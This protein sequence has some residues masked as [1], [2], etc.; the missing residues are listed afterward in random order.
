MDI[1]YPVTMCA[2]GRKHTVYVARGYDLKEGTL[3]ER[4]KYIRPTIFLGVPRVYEKVMEKMQ[5]VGA[6]FKGLVKKLSEAA[7]AKNKAADIAAQVG[8][9]GA[10]PCC[11]SFLNKKISAKA[12]DKLGLDQC[13][14]F[15]TGAA[16]MAPHV[17]EYWSSL[18]MRILECYGMSESTGLS[19]ANSN[20]CY[21][22]GTVG[23]PVE[24]V[25]VKVFKCDEQDFSKKKECPLAKDFSRPTEEEQGEICFR[26][27]TVMMG[28]LSNPDMEF[29]DEEGNSSHVGDVDEMFEKT[30]A[31]IDSEGWL[32]SGDKGTR[33]KHGM[34]KITGRY[35]ELIIGSGGENIA[36]VPIEDSVKKLCPGISNAMM[37]G[38][39]RKYNVMLVTLKCKGASGTEPGTDQLDGPALNIGA[40][41][42]IAEAKKDDAWTKAIQSAIDQTNSNPVICASPPWKV[43]KWVILDRDFSEMTGELT[44]TLKLKRSEA[45]KNF[46]SEI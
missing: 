19:T 35:K 10:E 9:T 43:Q 45:C 5:A 2:N 21:L 39:K 12:R 3:V 26:G 37:V 7:K 15:I 18:G 41:K 33:G 40:A 24:A 6:T 16:P 8:G 17:Y 27:R 20:D 11:K 38:D 22:W 14:L 42:T 13:E 46:A 34:I 31:A 36:P 30:A 29:F 4:L 28:Y 23:Y 44:A 1:V 32:H 25:E